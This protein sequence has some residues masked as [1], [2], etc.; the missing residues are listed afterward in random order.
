MESKKINQLATNVNPQ[1]SDLTTIG[2]PITG[3]LKKITWLQV[4]NLIGAQ[5]S[6]TLQQVTDNGN[7]TNDPI[8]T[9]GLTLTNLGTG[10]P[11]L[12]NGNFAG[13]YGYGL[14]NGV[15]TLDSGGKIPAAQLPSSV[16]EYKGTWNASTNTPTLADGTGDNGD[17]YLVNVAGS[18]NLGSGTI[19]FAVGDW[20][21][22]NGTIWQKSLNSNAVASVFGRTG[23]ITAQEGDYTIDQLGDVAITSAATNDYLRYNGS[24]WVNTQFPT[25]V[26]SDKLVLQVRNNSGATI[27]KGTVVYINGATAGYP[28]IAKALANDDATSAQTIGMVQD[29]ISNNSNGVV[30]IVGQITGIDTSAYTAGTQLYLSGTTAGTVTSTK[31]YAPLH[32]VYVG[33]VTTQNAVNGV[34]EVKVQNGVE[35]EE[36]HNVDALNPNNND[37]IFYNSTSELWEH[38]QI[39]TVLGYT[40]EQPLT[41]SS[42]LIRT[43]NTISIPAATGS[44]N[45]YLTSTD[46]TTF[47]NKLSAAITSLNGLTGATQTFA[48]GTTGTDFAINSAG[49]VHTFNLPIASATNTGKLSS[50]DWSTFNN[51]QNALTNPVTGTGTNNEIAYFNTNGSTIASLSTATYPSLT[52]LSYVKGVTSAIQTQLNAKQAQLN[53]TG[54]VKASGTTISYD[55]STY[56]TTSSAAST[57]LPLAGGTLT[58]ALI[59]T[60]A[61]FTSNSGNFTLGSQA[62]TAIYAHFGTKSASGGQGVGMRVD[63]TL[64]ATANFD[65]LYGLWVD[66]T[67]N[68]AGYLGVTTWGIVQNDSSRRNYFGGLVTFNSAI[69]VSDTATATAFIPTGTSVP[70]RGMYTSASNVLDFSA[71]TTNLLSLNYNT[72]LSTFNTGV[73]GSYFRI[74]NVS[75]AEYGINTENNQGYIGTTTSHGFNI[76]TNNT[77]RLTFHATTGAATFTGRVTAGSSMLLGEV[78]SSYSLVETTAGNGIWL[79]PAGIASPNG[80]FV[81]TSGNVGIGTTDPQAS[82]HIIKALGNNVISIGETGNNTRF[83]IGQEASY[84]G[85]YINS[86]NIDLKIQS[87]LAG[88]S[89]GNIIFQTGAS[90]SGSLA[91]RMTITS[92]GNVLLGTTDNTAAY[93]LNVAVNGGSAYMGVTNQAGGSGD[94]YLRIGFGTG[95]TVASIQGT[96][97]NVADDVNLALQPDGGNVG[98]GTTDPSLPNGGGLVLYKSD[99]PR[100]QFRNSTTGTGSLDG[101]GFFLS[102]NNFYISNRE[103]GELVFENGANSERAR[104]TSGGYLKASNNNTHS[105]TGNYHD[106]RNSAS[107]SDI[108]YMVHSAAS[109]YGIEMRFSGAS[110]NNTG[111]WFFWGEDSTA[112]RIR[113]NS[114]GGLANYQANNQNLSDI[115]TKKDIISLESY[116]DKFKALEIVKF[117]YNDQ[118]HDDYNIGVIAQQV[119]SVA[120]EFV[121]VDG[122]GETPEDGVPLKSIYTADLYHA[123]IKVLQEAMEKIEVLESELAI[124]KN[125]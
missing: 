24:S 35:L 95:A 125:K 60:T 43:T 61:S 97:V 28:T 55:N 123:T 53:G 54:F 2:D 93:R 103:T 19:S 12:T 68:T 64:T 52:E 39:S 111:N 7:T 110:P 3:Q 100:L 46:W 62:G 75:T 101:A 4:A 1:T 65:N 78:Q 21:V 98:I 94:R 23:T 45:G 40:P 5:A 11:Q 71:G 37:G 36:L 51:K 74:V 25:F 56:L 6:V 26:S 92:G 33:I 32:L 30:V 99:Y 29:N 77:P 57:Y 70:S 84:T 72:G 90:G 14:A 117:K 91:P 83:T 41:F 104:I 106:L 76:M 88:G 47:N 86:T 13:T 114:D 82:L 69:T 31:P 121:D 73:K 38:K 116:W 122:W 66:Y 112:L 120:P 81:N 115:R 118:T 15:A 9:A 18:Q 80:L 119:E 109:P 102:G 49:T 89:G 50:T 20:V 58:G 67:V 108:L 22:Y 16:M 17:V 27:N 113:L 42:P 85:N 124:L 107:G 10:V 96:R 63:G 48:T 8:T 87:Y 34:I 105:T 59:G 44:V 79:R